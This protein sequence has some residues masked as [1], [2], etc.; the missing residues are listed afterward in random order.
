MLNITDW[1]WLTAT[2][3]IYTLSIPKSVLP[4]QES[5]R[6]RRHYELSVATANQS[7]V[8]GQAGQ[9]I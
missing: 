5:K 2:L 4:A 8:V 3:S 6:L 7:T 9:V 1:P